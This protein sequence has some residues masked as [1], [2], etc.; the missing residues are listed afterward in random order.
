MSFDKHFKTF[1]TINKSDACPDGCE[2]K[3][4]SDIPAVWVPPP[5]K[6]PFVGIIISRDPTTEFIPYYNAAKS[7]NLSSWRELLFDTNA[8]PRWTY[9]RIEVF[10]Q[11]YMHSALSEK[12]LKKFRDTLFHSVYWTHLH[13][14]CTDKRAEASLQFKPT[15]ACYC[16]DQWLKSEIELAALENVRFIVTLGKNVEQWFERKGNESLV[17]QTIHLYHLPHPSGANMASWYPKD[18]Q[19]QKILEEKIHKLVLE[20]QKSP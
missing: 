19:T 20:C 14:C 11:R 13:K 7:R 16:A 5:Q 15:N 18:E 8:I 3:G 2:F 17:D 6:N 1:I 10:N 9:H 4:L 12:E